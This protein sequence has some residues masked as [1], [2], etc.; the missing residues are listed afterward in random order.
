MLAGLVHA[1][2][3]VV[4]LLG[5]VEAAA[6]AATLYHPW[7]IVAREHLNPLGESE[8]AVPGLYRIAL[9]PEAGDLPDWQAG[10]LFEIS[11]PT[12]HRRDYSVA[13]LP[14][15]GGVTLLVREVRDDEGRRGE[16]SGLLIETVPVN[17][18]VSARLRD[19]KPFHAP[20]GDGP[21]VLIAAGS[22][23]A[24]VRPHAIEAMRSGRKVWLILGERRP[25]IDARTTAEAQ[26]WADENKIARLDLAY[27]RISDGRG[28]YVQHVVAAE[29][30]AL[31][32]YLGDDG[33]IML[34][35]GLAMGKSVESALEQALGA[36]WIDAA[37]TAG[38]YHSD[39]Y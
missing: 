18:I 38:R 10:D 2:V 16:G 31:A 28:R 24:G 20:S 27:S 29:G 26:G 19:H 14:D 22:G 3:P 39:L 36:A 4:G 25:D 30:D 37:R 5:A 13:S 35:G 15:E 23:F 6:P 11:T 7:R 8:E 21:V 1:G 34:C 9:Q 33:A 17:G 32:R 12:G